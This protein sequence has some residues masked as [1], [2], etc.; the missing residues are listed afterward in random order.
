[1][2]GVR[3]GGC[4]G[5]GQVRARA[6]RRTR[7]PA[8]RAGCGQSRRAFAARGAGAAVQAEAAVK[9]LLFVLLLAL[10]GCTAHIPRPLSSAG[11]AAL[12]CAL[13]GDPP[14]SES[15]AAALDAMI[16]EM[17]REDLAFVIHVGDITG[18]KGPCTDEWL[19][20][21]KRQF[22]RFRHPF[23]IVPGDNEWV[24]CHRTGFDP[25]ER[26]KKFRELFESGDASLGGLRLE[27]PPGRY[28]EYPEHMRWIAGDVLL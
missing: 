19:A 2:S 28:Q 16:E 24:D 5:G 15:E 7:R 11:G 1:M 14:Y 25:M 22:E 27:R 3:Q 10:A 18:G 17:N 12:Q 26:L 9:R 6:A 8:R 4:F 13:I 21:R 20:A 23:V